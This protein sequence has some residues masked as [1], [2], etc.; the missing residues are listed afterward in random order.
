MEGALSKWT[1]VMKG[2]QYRWFVLDDNAGLFSY[3]TSREKMRRGVRRG[4]VRLKGA[5]VGIDDEDDSTF[6]ITVDNK[7][8]HFQAKDS[9]ERERWIR[10]LEDTVLRHNQLARR[11]TTSGHRKSSPVKMEDFERKLTE[12]DCYL[13]LLIDQ[14]QS[15]VEQLKAE[16]VE[17]G[18]LTEEAEQSQADEKEQCQGVVDRVNDMVETVKH[19]IVL[20][21]IAKNASCPVDGE[22]VVAIH[23]S[24]SQQAID[25]ENGSVRSADEGPE[26]VMET[27]S[28]DG[29]NISKGKVSPIISRTVAQKQLSANLKNPSTIPAVS[30]SSSDDDED[31]F[32][33]AEE[34]DL[35][36]NVSGT[37]V[38]ADAATL[39]EN[40]VEVHSVTPLTPGEFDWDSLYEDTDTME[41]ALDM[42]NN[43]SVITH[44]L[45]QVRIGMDLTKIVLP[46]FILE[47]RSLLEMYADFFV[48][49]TIFTDIAAKQTSEE[50]MIQVLKWYL[51]SFS[52]SR[53]G[54]NAKKPYNPILGEV[55]RCWWPLP[56]VSNQSTVPSSSSPTPG[57]I[58]WCSTNDVVFLA[59]QVSHHPPISAFYVECPDRRIS[60]NG[61][62]HTKSSFLGMSIAAHM[63]G[64]GKVS[65]QDSGEE[66]VVTFPS[67]YCRSILT[68]PWVE[69]GGKCELTCPQSGYRTEVEFKCKQFWG[70]EQNMVVAQV[71]GQDSKKPILKV[72]GEWNGRMMAKWANGKNETFLDVGSLSAQKKMVKSV[73]EQEKYESRRLWREVTAGLKAE[74]IE[75]ATEAKFGLEQRQREEAKER[76]ELGEKWE[77][78]MFHPIGE[79]WQFKHPLANSKPL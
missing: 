56:P 55:F 65:L 76:K 35:T 10:A 31:D 47:R 54:N 62:I 23:R 61:H 7:T 15:L 1:N 30:Y 49:P 2:W 53:K 67:G 9:E 14:N 26:D 73:A 58:P 71:Y 78:R 8:F 6:T 29:G 69:L 12:T 21:Q 20:L 37:G 68:T 74:R 57:P 50:R 72:E 32:Y 36:G 46:T 51:S 17:E 22:G 5:L 44:L 25:A 16:K 4:C 59:E 63:L 52:A 42:K 43:G 60:F 40:T 33:D 41:D 11:A 27:L 79:N 70:T 77:C 13:Q 34:D 19:A 39:M 24:R 38:G 75:E 18:E 66:Y 45:S 48:H 3:Y 28:V 64:E